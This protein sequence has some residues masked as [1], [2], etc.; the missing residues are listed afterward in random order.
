MSPSTLTLFTL[1]ILLPAATLSSAALRGHNAAR[2]G[3]DLVRSSCSHARYPDLCFHTLSSYPGPTDNPRDVAR[4][5]LKI[6][7]A[8]ARRVSS[9]LSGQ[10]ASSSSKSKRERGALADCLE[11]MSDSVDELRQ[12]LA[13]LKHLRGGEELRWQLSNAETWV[14]AALTNED[15]CL[16]GF[17]EVEAK[18]KGD[19]R[20]KISNVARVTSNA[21]YLIN[22][23]DEGTSRR[24]S[25]RGRRPARRA[26]FVMAGDDGR[27]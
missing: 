27:L 10:A 13:E 7:L 3:G 12:S 18:V 19:V 5:A 2:H 22:R 4:A 24:Q 8:R 21:L 20:R 9:Y 23:L 6:S 25:G 1:L 15:T 26:G 14:S 17:Q 16:D 11:Q